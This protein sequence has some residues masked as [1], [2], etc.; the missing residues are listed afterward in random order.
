MLVPPGID[1]GFANTGTEPLRLV[2]LFGEP[3][4]TG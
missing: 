4:A 2:L 1:H 3:R